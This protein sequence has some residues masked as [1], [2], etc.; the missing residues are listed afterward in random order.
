MPYAQSPGVLGECVA[1]IA[2][3][4][5]A[6]VWSSVRGVGSSS[7]RASRGAEVLLRIVVV[8]EFLL[9]LRLTDEF[10]FC[11]KNI[12]VVGILQSTLSW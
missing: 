10:V 11:F 2:V 9:P 8:L 12:Q 4:R 6:C 5:H 1:D 7:W 3:L